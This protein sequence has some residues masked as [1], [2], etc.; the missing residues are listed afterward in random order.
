MILDLGLIDYEDCHKIQ[1]ELVAKRKCGDSGDVFILAEHPNV[2]TIG[3]T[4]KRENL[5]VDESRLADKGVKVLDVER[6]G[7]ITFHGPG[8]LIVYPIVDL[9]QRGR[10]IHRHLRDLERVAIGLLNKYGVASGAIKGKTGVWLNDEKIGS[11]G[12]AATNWVTYHGMSIN[13]NVDLS[14]FAMINPC[15]MQDVTMTSLKKVLGKEVLMSEARDRLQG[16]II[17][18]FGPE[19]DRSTGQYAARHGVKSGKT[20]NQGG[21]A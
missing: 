5:L 8:Q 13:V 15:G 16:S 18:I 9:K 1:K 4:G 7:D 12:V 14:Y 3:R 21:K 6:G 19:E 17:D 20:H 2:F 10:D 11:I